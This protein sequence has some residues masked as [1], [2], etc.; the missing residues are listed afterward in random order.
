MPLKTM[1]LGTKIALGF[2]VLIAIAAML[3]GVGVV[4]MGA[5]QTE[6][7]KL[8]E[9][10][11]PEMN[12]AAELSAAANRLMVA[13]RGYIFTGNQAFYEEVQEEL[14]AA[15]TAIRQGRELGE[16][17]QHLKA[18]RNHLGAAAKAIDAYGESIQETR[19]I[20]DGMADNRSALD[21]SAEK[22][23]GVCNEFLTHQ[24]QAFKDDLAVAQKRVELVNEIVSLG[25]NVRETNFKGQTTNSIALIEVAIDF[26]AGLDP[27]AEELRSIT[28][29]PEDVR[30]IDEIEK[31]S[32]AYAQ[33]ME[34]FIQT[35]EAMKAAGEDMEAVV[36]GFMKTCS[37]FLDDLNKKV[38]AAFDGSTVDVDRNLKKID[39]VKAIMSGGNG[40]WVMS[41]KAQSTQ[42]AKLIQEAELTF[43]NVMKL[44]SHLRE[45]TSDKEDIER[46]VAIDAGIES[47][48]T[49]IG[50]YLK[51]FR[52]LSEYRSALDQAAARYVEQCE[53]FLQD[54]QKKLADAMYERN[55]KIM[56]V[57]TVI[58]L[59]NDIRVKIFRAQ[60]LQRPAIMEEALKNFDPIQ[61]K[62]EALREITRVDVNRERID[63]VAS[64][65]NAFKGAMLAYLAN[66][67]TMQDVAERGERAGG[68]VVSSCMR[69]AS[70]GME[71]T[72]KVATDTVG[73]LKS[74]SW[75]M[76]VGLI[77]AIVLGALIALFLTR[78][79]TGPVR[80]II[81]GL[82]DGSE[83]VASASH[84]VASGS[85][86]LAEG[87]S[88]QA[89]SIEETS[90]SLEEMASMTKKNADNANAA[91]TMMGEAG[92]I[93]E[94]VNRH[95]TDMLSAI[96]AITRSSEETGKIIK[97]IDE[98]AFQTNLLALNAAVEAARAGEAG[99]GFAVVADEVRHLALRAAE[100]AKNTSD[101]IKNTITAVKNGSDI[102]QTTQDA[103]KEN[104]KI[105][106]KVANLVEEISSASD[107]QAHGIEEINRAVTEMDKVVQQVA[108]NAEESAS[109]SEEMS[110][111]AEQ[112]QVYVTQ[113][114]SMVGGKTTGAMDT[115]ES[116]M[117]TE[118]IKLA[119]RERETDGV[120]SLDA[121]AKDDSHG[122]E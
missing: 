38:L 20:V 109:A 80:R 6:T 110:A 78:S 2:G 83:Q 57:N 50:A 86:S 52:T 103:F 94:N 113:L 41:L 40:A 121:P 105:A 84:Q 37:D 27:I 9:E 93:V 122:R 28:T 30:R 85:Q 14:Q 70:A 3:G 35:T 100:A 107:E 97:T 91:R 21:A 24:S 1:K 117:E 39:L 58:D 118:R 15:I 54:Q 45:I 114:V 96:E 11:V 34:G 74:S 87:A 79:I 76:A 16:N 119:L 89:A 81:E 73:L 55:A 42:D 95:M 67:R 10:Y 106:R 59:E 51:N 111:Q 120:R 26:L 116:L 77:A 36:T 72:G 19:R 75:V 47:Y 22:F 61:E 92:E 31:A 88:Q 63:Q 48:I 62:L 44:S 108:A 56:L 99:A 32:K 23:M 33:N 46:I 4:Q 102:T 82:S 104:M 101:L 18:A 17:S 8:A 13:M 90:S 66:W 7:E 60:A 5:V 68:E 43:R 12:V 53:S 64:A 112:I 29:T 98:I 49:A 25:V 115:E 65:G 69:M 71:A